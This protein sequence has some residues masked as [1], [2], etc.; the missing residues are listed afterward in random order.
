M[1]HLFAIISSPAT[2][3]VPITSHGENR[4]RTQRPLYPR[5]NSKIWLYNHRI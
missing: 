4:S 1:T 5:N 2:I 3:M